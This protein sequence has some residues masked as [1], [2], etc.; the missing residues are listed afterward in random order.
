MFTNEFQFLKTY[1]FSDYPTHNKYKKFL[2]MKLNTR[3]V[4]LGSVYV[5]LFLFCFVFVD[6]SHLGHYI[7]K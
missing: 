4:F 7:F 3:L 1:P 5:P 2:D 6:F